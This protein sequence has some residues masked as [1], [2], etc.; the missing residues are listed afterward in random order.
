MH[1]SYCLLRYTAPWVWT[2][3]D[4]HNSD[5][6]IK[7][8]GKRANFNIIDVLRKGSEVASEVE[9]SFGGWCQKKVHITYFC[10][11]LEF[12]GIGL[13]IRFRFSSPSPS[14]H[15]LLSLKRLFRE[16]RRKRLDIPYIPFTQIIGVWRN[17]ALP[18]A[19]GYERILA[20]VRRW[21]EPLKTR[22][23]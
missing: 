7:L 11:E 4:G 3:T 15:I 6:V 16:A 17:T 12:P 23:G 2:G 5:Q 21:A 10:E 9:D 22:E 13:V 8:V 20:E 14:T 1:S 18:P 19:S